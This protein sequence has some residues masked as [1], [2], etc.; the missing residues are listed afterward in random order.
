MTRKLKVEIKIGNEATLYSEDLARLLRT[1]ADQV[2]Q[3]DLLDAAHEELV[4]LL[5]VDSPDADRGAVPFP[6]REALADELARL[7][8][9]SYL[10]AR[11]IEARKRELDYQSRPWVDPALRAGRTWV[12]EDFL[13]RAEVHLATTS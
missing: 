5:K 10:L 9:N 8:E 3:Q 4:R 12:I 2:E 6:T 7:T 11:F 1:V 13:K